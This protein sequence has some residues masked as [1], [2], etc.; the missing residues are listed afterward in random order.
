MVA[1]GK[2]LFD[3]A[4]GRDPESITKREANEKQDAAN[5]E[6]ARIEEARR[7]FAL[8]ESPLLWESIQ[9]LRSA[10]KAQNT[11]LERLK[12]TFAD[13]KMDA[14]QDT[15]YLALIKERDNMV[16]RLIAVEAELD[17]AFLASVKY[18]ATRSSY[19]RNSFETLANED[20]INEARQTHQRFEKMRKN[21]YG[22][23]SHFH[24]MRKRFAEGH[25]T[26]RGQE[27][28]RGDGR[29]ERQVRREGRKGR[30]IKG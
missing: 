9:E 7:S 30:R 2:T 19:E 5:Q 25:G 14:S 15:D 13:L 6:A 8:K 21:K 16:R 29:Q 24:M 17:K 22:C 1:V 11:Q 3:L 12:K 23:L 20:G 26:C 28:V 10:I 4:T 18:E 27:G